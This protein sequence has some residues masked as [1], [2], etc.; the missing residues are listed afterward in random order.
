MSQSIVTPEIDGAIRPFALF[1]Q[2]E[3]KE[4]LRHSYA[5]PERLKTFVSTINNY[6]NLKTKPNKD[7]KVAIYY[8]KGPGQ[9]ALTAAGMEV[10]PSLYNLLLRMKQEGYNVSG[11]PANA[12]ELAKMIQAQGAVFNSYAEGAFDEFMKNG[13]PE[14]ITK[15]QYESWVKE[16]LRPE[17]YAEVVAADGEFPGNYM[18]TSDGCLGVARLQFG[19]I[20]LMPQ[21]AAG[22]GD[23]S[24]QVVHGT[25]AAPPHTYIASYLWMQHGFKADALIHFGTHGSLEFTPKNKLPYAAMTGRTVWSELF[26]TFISILS[27]M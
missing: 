19:N 15:E 24:F 3:D 13:N 22:S 11:L 17:K 6:L 8:Y 5:I 21:N 9:N 14:L 23:N 7:K 20:V 16:S 12:Q 1:A 2:Y 4:G 27:E 25:N 18:V 10:V 26:L